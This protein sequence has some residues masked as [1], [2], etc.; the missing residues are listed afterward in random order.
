MM[1]R[2]IRSSRSGRRRVRVVDI[3]LGGGFFLGGWCC[4]VVCSLVVMRGAGSEVPWVCLSVFVLSVVLSFR[5]IG[6]LEG[7]W[8]MGGRWCLGVGMRWWTDGVACAEREEG[9]VRAN[10]SWS[11][12]RNVFRACDTRLRR[13]RCWWHMAQS[14]ATG[15]DG[16]APWEQT[17]IPR[18]YLLNKLYLQGH[19]SNMQHLSFN[20]R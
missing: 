20:I 6:V 4:L 3:F 13:K 15:D 7:I 17:C 8:M 9:L 10:G 1:E 19:A 2:R 12:Y 16:I 14:W 5:S 18:I 11:R